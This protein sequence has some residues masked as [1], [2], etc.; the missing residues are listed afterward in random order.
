[1][2]KSK[3]G[4]I[5]GLFLFFLM[6]FFPAPDGLDSAAW[7]TAVVGILMA[8]WWITEAIPIPA[9]SLLPIVLF[10]VLQ[11]QSISGS[12]APY[13]NPL[14]FLFM[15]GFMI[16]IAMQKW[17]L[18]KRIA[19]NIVSFVGTKPTS[20]IIGFILASA[21]LSMWVSNTATALMMLPI[22]LSVIGISAKN[23]DMSSPENLLK[24]NFELVLVLGIAY[25]C[26]IGG[27]ATLIGTPPNALLAGFALEA[28][29]LEI[30]FAQWLFAGLPIV[31]I[32]LPVMYFV[33]AKIVYPVTLQEL[34]GGGEFIRNELNILGS[35]SSQ[36]KKSGCGFHSY[37]DSLDVQVG[38]RKIYPGNF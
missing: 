11:I 26:N 12:T 22:A 25:G 27:V 17:N 8:V 24:S 33:L 7:K 34:P 28:Y 18:H 20:I 13:A 6:L 37:C 1:M 23:K 31:L 21:F 32:G 10:P 29:G 2:I 9:T 14:I 16:A 3:A 19:L 38:S 15:G 30:G 5:A 4:L 35:M 36:E